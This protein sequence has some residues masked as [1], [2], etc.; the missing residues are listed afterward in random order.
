MEIVSHNL[1]N[2]RL[3][4]KD[5]VQKVVIQSGGAFVVGLYGELGS[6]KT[7]FMKYIAEFLGVKNEIQS[8]TFVIE[9]IYKL[10]D[11]NS[12]DDRNA[13]K[14]LIHIDTYRIENESEMITLG[15]K[16]I[17]QEKENIIFVEWPER[18]MSIMP[19]HIKIKFSHISENERGIVIEDFL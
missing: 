15:W 17:V 3:F 5:F 18:I 10:P 7:T 6:G 4:A 19:G 13:F 14:H 2:T 16:E 8:P 1:E 9:K 12:F 11:F